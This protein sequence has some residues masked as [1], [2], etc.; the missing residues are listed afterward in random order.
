MPFGCSFI[1]HLIQSNCELQPKDE[2][3]FP[4]SQHRLSGSRYFCW[5]D[6]CLFSCQP[7]VTQELTKPE[8]LAFEFKYVDLCQ[9]AISF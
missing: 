6:N 5:E 1:L 8:I 7:A 4:L 2:V 3:I 9:F